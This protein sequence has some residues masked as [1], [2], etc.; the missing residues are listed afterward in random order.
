MLKTTTELIAHLNQDNQSRNFT[1]INIL[2]NTILKCGGK[3]DADLM[4]NQYLK[5]PFDFDHAALL[6]VL[7][8]FGD[9]HYAEKLFK[10]FIK[11]NKL[12]EHADPALLE[13]L[14][15]LKY[16]S[17]KPVLADYIFGQPAD[18]HDLSKNAVLGLLHFDCDEYQKEIETAIENCYHKNLFPEFVPALVCKLENQTIVLEKLYELGSQYASTD[19]NAGIILGFS[20]S[21]QEGRRYFNKVLFDP[22]WET[23]STA[24]GTIHFAYR[25]M[26]NAGLTFKEIYSELKQISDKEQLAY[27]LAVFFALIEKKVMDPEINFRES[28][29]DLYN[30]LFTWESANESN[31]LADLAIQAN[32]PGEADHLEKLIELKM[33]E[34]SIL[35][36]YTP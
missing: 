16:E 19:C 12:V 25:G 17:I 35:K 6:P 36:N 33:Q 5:N 24:T 22:I 10:I 9:K 11:N 2:V 29:A 7:K 32:L 18:D 27:S 14:G 21:G 20:L 34:E 26:K 15:H 8:K 31:N 30:L 28:F 1:V 3:E 23:Y 4:L 13:V